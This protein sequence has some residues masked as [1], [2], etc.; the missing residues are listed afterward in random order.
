MGAMVSQVTSLSIVYSTIHSG[1][2]QRKHQSS[3]SLA[4]VRG[5]HRWPVNSPHKWPI[6]R[7]MFPF[8]EVIMSPQATC[9]SSHHFC[10]RMDEILYN[11]AW[12]YFAVLVEGNCNPLI[13]LINY[14]RSCRVD[15]NTP[16]FL[17]IRRWN[18]KKLHL[19]SWHLRICQL[20]KPN[21][22]TDVLAASE[23][24]ASADMSS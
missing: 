20:S 12:K 1:A 6:T 18:I 5:I 13:K 14:F 11:V 23:T 9:T 7:K 8:D 15:L 2:D 19:Y 10:E 4:F 17:F 24:R 16:T 22:S 3:A 21:M